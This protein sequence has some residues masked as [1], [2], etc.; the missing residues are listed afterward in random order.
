IKLQPVF[1]GLC[2]GVILLVMQAI[3][4][5]LLLILF[6][7]YQNLIP[8]EL[9]NNIN[10]PAVKILLARSSLILGFGFLLHAFAVLYAALRMSNW[11]WLFVRGVGLYV[12]MFLCIMLARFA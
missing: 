12:M 2:F 3:G 6:E 10:N 5:P 11:W 1:L 9:Q 4:K 7:K 8:G